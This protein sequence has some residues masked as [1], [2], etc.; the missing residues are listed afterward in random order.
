MYRKPLSGF[1]TTHQL[2]VLRGT[3]PGGKLKGR[4]SPASKGWGDWGLL[5]PPW[6]LLCPPPLLGLGDCCALLP[7]PDVPLLPDPELK[8]FSSPGGGALVVGTSQSSVGG[9]THLLLFL[10]K[11]SIAGQRWRRGYPPWQAQ[12]LLHDLPK[13]TLPLASS[14]QRAEMWGCLGFVSNSWIFLRCF[15]HPATFCGQSQAWVSS[16]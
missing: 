15:W 13:G 2:F 11:T 6:G 10:S 4:G 3:A 14:L 7:D 16:L 9:V 1:G 8:L 5:W 12:Y